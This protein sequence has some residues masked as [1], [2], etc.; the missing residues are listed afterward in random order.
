MSRSYLFIPGN[1]PSMIQNLDVFDSDAIILDLED[2]VVTYDK[3]AA[4]ILVD[5]FI[6]MVQPG[7]DLY[8]RINDVDSPY[9]QED[10]AI[11]NTCD[12]HGIV[13]P[14]A[15]IN[16]LQILIKKTHHKIIPIIES[17]FAVLDARAIVSFDRVIAVLLGA[18]DCTKEMNINRTKGAHE[19]EYM[20]QYV[21]L[22]AHAYQKEA[23]DTPWIH[24][25]DESGLLRDATYA[26]SVGFTAKSAIHPN[27]I[28]VINHVFTPTPQEILEAKRIVKK[29]NETQKGAFSLDGKMVDM[30]IIEKARKVL[31]LAEK[32]HI[33]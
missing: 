6:K 29:A 1:T 24:K 8:V 33:V 17:P 23:I 22:V 11:L 31:Q 5:N 27:H 21:A 9:F 13:L 20:R 16:A 10:I 32:Y 26:K 14:K 3:D 2:S 15:S 18:E 25:D 19:I 12:I 28:A 7:V 30:P 4:R